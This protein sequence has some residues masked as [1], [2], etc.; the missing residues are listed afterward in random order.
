MLHMTCWISYYVILGIPREFP[1]LCFE[2]LKSFFRYYKEVYQK[3]LEKILLKT[4]FAR[5]V[6]PGIQKC[7]KNP[8]VLYSSQLPN[9]IVFFY[10]TNFYSVNGI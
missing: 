4:C 10:T 5:F 1:K 3:N 6:T 8:S 2:N 9:F 7:K